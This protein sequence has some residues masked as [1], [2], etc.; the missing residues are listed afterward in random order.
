MS[1]QRFL[2]QLKLRDFF[3]LGFAL[4]SEQIFNWFACWFRLH[5][6]HDQLAEYPLWEGSS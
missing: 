3:Y 1:S 2:S 5:R 6:G 4:L